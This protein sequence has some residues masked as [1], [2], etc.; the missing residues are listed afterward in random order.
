MAARAIWKG[1]LRFGDLSVPVKFYSAVEDRS[2]H[3][4]LLHAEDG[5]PVKQRMVDPATGDAVPREE[6]RRGLEVEDGVYVVFS[7]EEL[8]EL[9]PDDS[10]DIEVTRFVPSGAVDPRWYDRPYYL[11][12]DGDP[13]AYFALVDALEDAG[14]EGIAR[15]VMRKK[16]YRGALRVREGYLAMLT[17]RSA[18]RV[19]DASEL[20]SPE[21]REAEPQELELAEQLVGAL[22]GPFE[23]ER[24]ENEYRD[25][26]LELIRAKAR[27][28]TIEL[29]EARPPEREEGSLREALEASVRGAGEAA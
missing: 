3:F 17:V 10:R 19:V 24:Y 25:R 1:V 8:D 12:P 29:E 18:Q 5:V 23:P 26:V 11:E 4:R 28:E 2:V 6:V 21:G 22:A 27:G 13:E 9:E 15:W 20:E 16:R 14:R 7:D